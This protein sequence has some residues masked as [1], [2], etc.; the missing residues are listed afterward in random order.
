MEQVYVKNTGAP[1]AYAPP[2]ASERASER[3]D[4][5]RTTSAKGREEGEGLRRTTVIGLARNTLSRGSQTKSCM[6]KKSLI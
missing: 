4:G 5:E 1:H 6:N 2:R 3:G